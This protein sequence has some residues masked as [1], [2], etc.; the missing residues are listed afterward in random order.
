MVISSNRF[1]SLFALFLLSVQPLTGVLYYF[2][3]PNQPK[4]ITPA[5]IVNEVVFGQLDASNGKMLESIDQLLAN[6][7]IPLLQQYEVRLHFLQ[8]RKYNLFVVQDWGALKN[9]S[10]LNVQ[11]FL[12]AMNQ[13]TATVNGASDNLGKKGRNERKEFYCCVLLFQLI[14]SNQQLVIMI[15]HYQ[16]QLHQMIIKQWHKM[17]ILSLTVKN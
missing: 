17:E 8:S 9:R 3:R 1:L 15:V 14:K 12:D 2:V 7:L 5:N 13:F 16:L 10:N 4:A 11:D 6:I